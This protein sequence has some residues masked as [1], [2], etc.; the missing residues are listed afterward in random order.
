M[1]LNNG[2]GVGKMLKNNYERIMY[3]FDV[4]KKGKIVGKIKMEKE[5]EENEKKDKD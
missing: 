3:K 1:G 5:K 4:L 2:K